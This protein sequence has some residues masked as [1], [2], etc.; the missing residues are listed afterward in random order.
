MNILKKIIIYMLVLSATT[1]A[2][3]QFYTL[4]EG[5]WTGGL[6]G[7]I[8]WDNYKFTNLNNE[9]DVNNFN[10][11]FSSRNGIFLKDHFSIGFDFQWRQEIIDRE[12]A[13]NSKVSATT[14]SEKLGFLGLWTRYYFPIDNYRWA[15]FPEVSL[16][17]AG[18]S[19]E[20]QPNN[21]INGEESFGT[22]SGFAYNLGLGGA[23]F[24]SNSVAFEITLRYTG[25]ALEGDYELTGNTTQEFKTNLSIFN[26]LFGFQIYL[27]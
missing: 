14:N 1:Y 7:N 15:V 20:D 10:F 22:A 5:S 3:R 13:G 23:L 8:G 11:I 21:T 12:P 9:F 2:Q 27:P 18:Y 26:V 24:V 17:Y 16:G 19:I 6:S 4:Q 25:G